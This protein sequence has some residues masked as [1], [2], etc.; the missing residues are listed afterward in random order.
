MN[1]VYYTKLAVQNIRKNAQTYLPYLLTCI[2][3]IGTFYILNALS[4]DTG[5]GNTVRVILRLGTWVMGIF[6]ACFLF[7]TNSFLMKRRKKEFGLLSVLGMER[8]HIARI[9]TLETLYVYALS[10]L[11]G[12]GAGLLFYKLVHLLLLQMLQFP[13]KFGFHVTWAALGQ[14]FGLFTVIFL[15]LLLWSLWQI[16]RVNPIELLRG[17]QVGEREPKARWL[18]AILGLLMLGA[19]YYISVT[20][21]EPIMVLMLFFLAVVLVIV[22][23]YLLFIAGGVAL[24]KLLRR[25]RNYYYRPNHF[26]AVSGMMYRMKQNAAG[27]GTICILATM[28]LVMLSSTAALY[29][30]MEDGLNSRYPRDVGLR[31][32]MTEDTDTGAIDE[33]IQN[34]LSAME[35]ERTDAY[36]YP[37]LY[38]FGSIR[39]GG[40]DLQKE[41]GAYGANLYVIAQGDY[42]RIAGHATSLQPGEGVLVSEEGAV[43]SQTF[44][45][46]GHTVRV[47][48][49]QG[50]FDQFAQ[51]GAYNGDPNPTYVLVVNAVSDIET[52]DQAVQAQNGGNTALQYQVGFDLEADDL[53]EQAA[54]RAIADN[55]VDAGIEHFYY[56]S[57]G[58]NRTEFL[59]LYG[60][61]FFLGIFLTGV[62]LLATVLIIYYKQIS[63]GYDDQRRYAI[64]QKVGLSAGEARSAINS[65]ILTMF[66]LPL[67]A[68]CVHLGFAFPALVRLMRLLNLNNVAVMCLSAG[69]CILAFTLFYL[70]VYRLTAGIYYRLVDARKT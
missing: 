40:F 17:G 15:L 57:K 48:Q 6:S 2:C 14:T 21:Q 39:D 34:T 64:M 8:R 35:L 26:I 68:A 69:L 5:A 43:Q 16:T 54:A 23:T 31:L 19:G 55:L 56:E 62:F 18:M 49:Q 44:T 65:Q 61:L 27:L 70:V 41:S 47:A 7:Y 60:G 67:V 3:A 53:Q 46:L 24:L 13:I 37:T 38:L 42:H 33:V 4:Y 29:F 30:G 10:M 22:G 63:E 28:V 52:L 32:T 59:Q 20:T 45:L 58:S 25:N 36:A 50:K 1:R 9:V 12:L 11:L 51:W 66:F